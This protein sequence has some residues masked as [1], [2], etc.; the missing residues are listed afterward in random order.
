MF[1]TLHSTPPRAWRVAA[2]VLLAGAAVGLLIE[3]SYRAQLLRAERVRAPEAAAPFADALEL[4]FNQ[5]IGQLGG[6]RAFVDAAP[7]RAALDSA[8]PVVAAGLLQTAGEVRSVYLVED[9]RIVQV[10]PLA[11]ARQYIG[12]DL[13]TDTRPGIAANLARAARS[14][15]VV[16]SGPM[17]LLSGGRGLS[18]RQRLARPRPGMPDM[19][20]MALDLDSLLDH[21]ARTPLPAGLQIELR[22]QRGAL[23]GGEALR[24]GATFEPGVELGDVRFVLRVAPRAGWAA[25]I[26]PQL[27]PI[28]VAIVEI[29]LL[30]AVVALSVTGARERLEQAVEV[31]T[32]ELEGANAR[33]RRESNERASLEEQLLHSQKMEAVGTLASGVAH[34]FNNLLTAILGFTQL[35]EEQVQGVLDDGT[36]PPLQAHLVEVRQDLTEILKAADR[37]SLLTSQLLAFSRRQK[38]SPAPLDANVVVND[39]ERM[40]QR[41]I[42]ETVSLV[43]ELATDHLPIMADS[44]QFSQVVL[45]LVVN[46]RD[47]LPRGGLVRVHTG[48]LT[49]AAPAADGPVAGLSAGAWVLVTV[50]DNGTGMTPEVQ[51]RMFEPFFTTK[52]LGHGTGL[53]L[54]TVYG[55]V[56]QAGGQLFV[57]SLPG[58]GTTVTVAWPRFEGVLVPPA[59]SPADRERNDAL[60]LVVEDEP[61]LRRLVAEILRRRG[62]RV[63]VAEHGVAALE[64]LDAGLE[65]ALVVTDVVMPRMG[66]RELASQIAS[67]GLTVPVLFMSGYQAGEELP[68]DEAHRFIGKPFTP[69]TLVQAVRQAIDGATVPGAGGR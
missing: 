21:A 40:L 26:A 2:L 20:S 57:D 33:L 51:A 12:H 38:V 42:G 25:A 39:L 4:A 66:G 56:T 1:L 8:F 27:F 48:P 19:V 16:V 15:T 49:L 55:I 45:N 68:D 31:R 53:G 18:L 63:R 44:G 6:V 30:L 67:R 61:G 59:P 64:Q 24:D 52:P 9:G 54:S 47:A 3:R 60:V 50:E 5:H 28:R 13:R 34:D 14:D 37:A 36:D 7:N 58:R 62:H 35:A 29:V 65:P 41:L 17:P 43:T 32:R 23:L 69:D 11:L 10:Y 22:D 46:A